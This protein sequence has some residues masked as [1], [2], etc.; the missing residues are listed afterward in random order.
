MNASLLCHIFVE[1][2]ENI[3]YYCTL[4]IIIR[5]CTMVN[6]GY[7]VTEN[8]TYYIEPESNNL[9]ERHFVFRQSDSTL[10]PA[11]CGT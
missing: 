8:E 3:M 6:R 7:V 2:V 10:P 9:Q 1:S 5:K 4:I 11:K